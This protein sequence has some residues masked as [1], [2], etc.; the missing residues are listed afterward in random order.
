[1]K[2]FS[3]ILRK[4]DAIRNEGI[5][6]LFKIRVAKTMGSGVRLLGYKS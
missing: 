5:N 6:M 3:K 1:M 4:E 2:S